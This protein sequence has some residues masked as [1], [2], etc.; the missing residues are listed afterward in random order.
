VNFLLILNQ[1]LP[2]INAESPLEFLIFGSVL[3]LVII[4][5]AMLGSATCTA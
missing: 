3:L 1:K 4:V 2:K 5:E